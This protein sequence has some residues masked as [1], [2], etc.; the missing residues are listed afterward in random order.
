MNTN[1]TT[2]VSPNMAH[3]K[4]KRLPLEQVS[5]DAVWGGGV[6]QS[7]DDRTMRMMR[8]RWDRREAYMRYDWMDRDSDV[9]RALTMIA[10]QCTQ[11]D[12]EGYYFE[13]EWQIENPTEQE[14]SI[15]YNALI[16]WS[17][18]NKW[19][20]RLG[21][22]VRNVLK[23]GDWFLFRNP[24]TFQLYNLHPKHVIG[25][26][27]DPET[28][29]VEAWAIRNF[30]FDVENLDLAVDSS[31]YKQAYSNISTNTTVRQMRVLPAIHLVHL[32]LAEGAYAGSASVDEPQDRHTTRFPFGESL[33]EPL[34][35]TFRQREMIEQ[36]AVIH[37]LQRASSR[38]V[39]YID[40]GR[41]RPD[42]AQTMVQQF[43]QELNQRRTP[44][45]GN[46]GGFERT[47]DSVFS[48]MSQI[49][50]IFI[51]LRFDQKGSKVDMLEGQSW[52]NLPELEY[53]NEKL[54]RGFRI[55]YAW[56]LGPTKGGAL[57][58]D[59]RVGTAYQEEIEFS[60]HCR[61]L[62]NIMQDQFDE[63]FKL[64]C[65]W[66]DLN[67]NFSD[68]VLSLIPPD[69]FEES[70][71]L[72][73]LSEAIAVWQGAKD[74]RWMSPRW[75]AAHTLGLTEDDLLENER[76]KSEELNW[77]EDD[78][79][80]LNTAPEDAMGG[81]AGGP[82][83]PAMMGQNPPASDMS[84]QGGEMGGGGGGMDMG[85]GGATMAPLGGGMGEM[86]HKQWDPRKAL[87]ERQA[88]KRPLT[89]AQRD[90]LFEGLKKK[91][92]P[93]R[94]DLFE[95]IKSSDIVPPEPNMGLS[96]DKVISGTPNDRAIMSQ[97][98]LG[99]S[100]ARVKLSV[101]R[102]IRLS[103]MARRIENEKRRKIVAQIY[104]QPPAED[105]MGGPPL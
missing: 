23:Y 94:E 102:K 70:K 83:G 59:G 63:E 54:F 43:K 52:D 25:A 53:M 28:N 18:M 84:S 6:V 73:R 32:S 69:N 48:P 89:R 65:T 44:T 101:I 72:A 11:E 49:E 13:F 29:E 104:A 60:R 85:G 39:W 40:T 12:K 16:T 79:N 66:R 7:G 42:M 105:S 41:A 58:N 21:K 51:P 27:V 86:A 74:E 62:Q 77:G 8:G 64:Y 67:I 2:V 17:N 37:R 33:L 46:Q 50:D 78:S 81:M 30:K 10:D 90:S 68:F 35:G 57:F 4:R 38:L 31:R 3:R 76:M 80:K 22:V 97:D 88:P 55:P 47:V 75:W 20:K 99:Q 61:K 92:F 14:S 36:S 15:L 95:D 93:R 19:R 82:G 1:W 34:Y 26:F 91:A 96:G 9:S 56:M 24:N 100:G 98:V 87:M 103:H 71:K 5:G 45:V